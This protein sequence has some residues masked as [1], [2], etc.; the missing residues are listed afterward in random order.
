MTPQVWKKLSSEGYSGFLCNYTPRNDIV[1]KAAKTFWLPYSDST[2]N[3]QSHSISVFA[4]TVS[5]HVCLR[6]PGRCRDQGVA[7][8][9]L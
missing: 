2:Y 3:F 5:S 4:A 6:Q 1:A 9:L 8:A 7:I